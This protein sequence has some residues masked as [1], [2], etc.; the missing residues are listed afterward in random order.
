MLI[1]IVVVVASFYFGRFTKMQYWSIILQHNLCL[2]I[3]ILYMTIQPAR[4]R[5]SP[6]Q[7]KRTYDSKIDNAIYNHLS[8]SES[9]GSTEMKSKLEGS[10]G[11]KI[12][13]DTYST[14][15]KSHIC[16]YYQF[17]WNRITSKSYFIEFLILRPAK[18]PQQ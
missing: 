13:Y 7:C 11:R 17:I 8:R 10:L 18:Y 2:F 4:Q 5:H 16:H 15:I 1:H 3:R 12:S 6:K 9:L 14:H